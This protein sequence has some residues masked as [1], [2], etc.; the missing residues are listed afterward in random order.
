MRSP[1]NLLESIS[2]QISEAP[3]VIAVTHQRDRGYS[4][5]LSP[6]FIVG[7]IWEVENAERRA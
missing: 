3:A 7:T 6:E 1:P 4:L 2:I 5:A